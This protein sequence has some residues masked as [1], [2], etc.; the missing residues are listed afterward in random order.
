MGNIWAIT[1]NPTVY[2]QPEMFNPDRFL[3]GAVPDAPVFGFGRRICP[4][5]YFAEASLLLAISHV[6]LTLNVGMALGVDGKEIV[7]PVETTG[8]SLLC[9]PKEFGIKL[10]PRSKTALELINLSS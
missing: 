7:P 6:L 2:P 5:Q 10:T 1:R 8:D 3:D 9:I 4:G